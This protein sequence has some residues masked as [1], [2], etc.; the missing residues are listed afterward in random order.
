MSSATVVNGRMRFALR[1]PAAWFVSFLALITHYAR[2]AERLRVEELAVG[3]ELMDVTHD[4]AA[5]LKITSAVRTDYPRMARVRGVWRGSR[6]ACTQAPYSGAH[7]SA[8]NRAIT[9]TAWDRRSTGSGRTGR[10]PPGIAGRLHR[11]DVVVRRL[12]VGLA[13]AAQRGLFH[14]GLGCAVQDKEAAAVL[15]KWW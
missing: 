13:C 10:R 7:Q 6:H 4:R 8:G 1:D 9:R 15:R 12:F 2:I 3:T 5:R 14:P 11:P